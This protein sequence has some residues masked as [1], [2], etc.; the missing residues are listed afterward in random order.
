[1]TVTTTK[2]RQA[3]LRPGYIYVPEPYLATMLPTMES[4]CHGSYLFHLL[5]W[6][7][8]AGF[9]KQGGHDAHGYPSKHPKTQYRK[10]T[11]PLEAKKVA[12][13]LARSHRTIKTILAYVEQ[14]GKV[15]RQA[16]RQRRRWDRGGGKFRIVSVEVY[17]YRIPRP[18]TMPQDCV[19][20][21]DYFVDELMTELEDERHGSFLVL[22][23]V[24]WQTVGQNAEWSQLSVA[25]IAKGIGRDDDTANALLGWFRKNTTLLERRHVGPQR[26]EYRLNPAFVRA[27]TIPT[28]D[29]RVLSPDGY[30]D[31]PGFTPGPKDDRY[32][33]D[34]FLD[35]PPEILPPGGGN[36]P[37]SGL[38]TKE[39]TEILPRGGQKT[40]RFLPK[41]C[42]HKR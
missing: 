22:L 31:D 19:M 2:Q 5:V 1:M 28:E 13:R 26:Y 41:S 3:A 4:E 29:T 27:F 32:F 36:L 7:L 24:W 14:T 9:P 21:P 23:F 10:W 8:T 18:L 17:K 33:L 25:D 11:L 38:G 16:I 42:P 15:Q 12:R 30:V 34:R 6:R 40:G 35:E 39:P 20:I 37:K